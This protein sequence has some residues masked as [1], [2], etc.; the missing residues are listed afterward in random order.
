MSSPRCSGIGPICCRDSPRSA[1]RPAPSPRPCTT[2][3]SRSARSRRASRRPSVT[4]SPRGS[5]RSSP[6]STRSRPSSRPRREPCRCRLSTLRA[7]E[8]LPSPPLR[9]WR[10]PRQRRPR[11]PS[12]NGRISGPRSRTSPSGTGVRSRTSWTRCGRGSRR[13][14]AISAAPSRA[15]SP[16]TRASWGSSV[17][18][19]CSSR[20]V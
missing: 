9:P 20:A 2:P 15:P 12:Q 19:T 13:R 3:T 4:T 11:P 17:C 14:S 8:P 1:R 16:S 7:P 6:A 10:L 5:T 18:S